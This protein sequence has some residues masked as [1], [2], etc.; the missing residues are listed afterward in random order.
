MTWSKVND[1]LLS[2]DATALGGASS[3]SDFVGTSA[4]GVFHI[5]GDTASWA[6]ANNGLTAT[7]IVALA[8]DPTSPSTFWAA[9][10]NGGVFRSTDGGA[11]WSSA[12]SG[13]PGTYVVFVAADPAN[14]NNPWAGGP[15]ALY[16]S[17]NAGGSWTKTSL[18]DGSVRSFGFDAKTPSTLYAGTYLSLYRSTDSGATWTMPTNVTGGFGQF[19]TVNAIVVDPSNSR[20]VYAGTANGDTY[21][22]FRSTDGGTSWANSNAGLNLGPYGSVTGLAVDPST[23]STLFAT[24]SNGGVFRSINAGGSWSP[25]GA[26]L[27]N[28]MANALV[29][30][31]GGVFVGTQ[32]ADARQP[33]RDDRRR[34]AP[35]HGGGLPRC[36]R[37]RIGRPDT[38]AR[39][40]VRRPERP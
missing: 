29:V 28:P 5:T 39:S 32:G 6:D 38:C 19:G 26:P 8:A 36:I 31:S 2:I 3:A 14:A 23:S 35:L 25:Y 24:T 34:P 22:F 15:D 4:N 40:A 9:V 1:G 20:N 11:T 13:I 33:R 17:V 12:R 16:K 18:L 30:N 7:E 10:Q 37:Q 27:S 21:G